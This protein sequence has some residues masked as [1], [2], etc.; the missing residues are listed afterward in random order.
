[1]S[2]IER[3]TSLVQTINDRD[4][5]WTAYSSLYDALDSNDVKWFV[6]CFT[7]EGSIYTGGRGTSTGTAALAQYIPNT[8][9]G[10]PCHH[11][12]NFRILTQDHE[13]AS[14]T[15]RYVLIA[16]DSGEL[17][18]RGHTDDKLRR[19]PDGAWR[20]ESARFVFDWVSERYASL[21][22]GA[23][24]PKSPKK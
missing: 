23:L 9:A 1:M 24:E 13:R 8:S 17:Y 7:D 11:F 2:D 14:A 10:R 12:V 22:R 20:F 6:D 3:L 21:G 19:C 5:I 4:L 16:A 15:S 18:A